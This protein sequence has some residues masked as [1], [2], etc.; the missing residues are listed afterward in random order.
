MQIIV[1]SVNILIPPYTPFFHYLGGIWG[2][3]TVYSLY[4]GILGTVGRVY[5]YFSSAN[6]LL[7]LRITLPLAV[8]E[9]GYLRH[10]ITAASLRFFL[11]LFNVA[12]NC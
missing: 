1:S 10:I 2:R 3:R 5:P 8:K 11:P 9:S 6:R 12:N 7:S 4:K